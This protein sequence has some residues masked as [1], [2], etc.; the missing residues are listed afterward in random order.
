M[1]Y[2]VMAA[3]FIVAVVLWKHLV[4]DVFMQDTMLA[5]AR[6]NACRERVNE[7]RAQVASIELRVRFAEADKNEAMR[8]WQTSKSKEDGARW[9]GEQGLLSAL[10]TTLSDRRIEL[11]EAQAEFERVNSEFRIKHGRRRRSIF[12]RR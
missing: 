7:K 11:E 9:D 6:L 2:L 8:A 10:L 1:S 4:L 12:G 5:I 3:L